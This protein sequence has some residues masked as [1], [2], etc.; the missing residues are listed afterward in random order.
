MLRWGVKADSTVRAGRQGNERDDEVPYKR[1]SGER[2]DEVP[3]KRRSGER[4]DGVGIAIEAARR[5][6]G[7][8]AAKRTGKLHFGPWKWREA[9]EKLS[10]SYQNRFR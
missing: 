2:D 9:T 10:K 1:R 7:G 3:Y 4:D 6:G 5:R 8:R